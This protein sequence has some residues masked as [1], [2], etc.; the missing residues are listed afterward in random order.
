MVMLRIA[1]KRIA[2]WQSVF[3]GKRSDTEWVWLV[4]KIGQLAHVFA[5]HVRKQFIF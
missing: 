2:T 5:G 4:M 1:G 3:S